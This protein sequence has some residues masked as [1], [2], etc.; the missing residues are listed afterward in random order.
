MWFHTTIN[1]SSSLF[2]QFI[3]KNMNSFKI[4]LIVLFSL[5][6]SCSKKDS[7]TSVELKKETPVNAP[8]EEENCIHIS[9][10][11]CTPI[12]PNVCWVENLSGSETLICE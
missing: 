7:I 3:G 5:L 9:G 12:E 2:L 6:I 4:V 11:V 10:S 1:N 8:K